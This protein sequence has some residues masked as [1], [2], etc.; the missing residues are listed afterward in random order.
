MLK[1]LSQWQVAKAAMRN[2]T[3]QKSAW[4]PVTAEAPKKVVK[5]A[6]LGGY[7]CHDGKTAL[8]GGQLIAVVFALGEILR[9]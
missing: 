3:L 1:S 6:H 2:A 5:K 8:K 9:R 7:C 4:Q